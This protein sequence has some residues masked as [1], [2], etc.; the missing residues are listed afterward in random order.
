MLYV[1]N[2]N[3]NVDDPAM[4][5]ALIGFLSAVIASFLTSILTH[6]YQLKRDK[7]NDDLKRKRKQEESDL[8]RE[9]FMFMYKLEL[10]KLPM[11]LDAAIYIADH[12]GIICEQRA[13]VESEKRIKECLT[14]FIECIEKILSHENA[15]YLRQVD[16]NNLSKLYDKSSSLLGGIARDGIL[17]CIANE[18]ELENI[19]DSYFQFIKK[20]DGPDTNP[21]YDEELHSEAVL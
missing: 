7:R 19:S 12:R 13:L 15:K 3:L 14:Q 20:L 21:L 11:Y 2:I 5:G 4:V 16:I 1:F 6:R 9:R 18:E 17:E 10:L 8:Y